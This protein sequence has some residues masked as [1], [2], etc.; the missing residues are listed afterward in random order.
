MKKKVSSFIALSMLASVM[1]T[2]CSSDKDAGKGADSSQKSP[3]VQ[4]VEFPLKEKVKYSFVQSRSDGFKPYQTLTAW[5]EQYEKKSNVQIEWQDWGT[6]DAY[7]QKSKLAFASGDL[8][9]AL[10][11]GFVI[12]GNEYTNYGSQGLLI[13]MEKMINKDIMPNLTKLIEKNPDLL[14][15]MT[16]PDGHV[17]GLPAYQEATTNTNDTILY[18]R[19]WLDK[20]GLKIPT[21]TDEFYEYLKAIKASKDLNGN[22]KDDEIP[23]TF[24]FGTNGTVDKINGI[25]SLIG[26]TGLVLPQNWVDVKD[27]KVIFVPGQPEYKEAMKYLNKLASEGLIDKEAFTMDGSAYTAKLTSKVPSV[28]VAIGWSTAQFNTP[29]GSDV[30]V[31][32][33]PLKGPDGKQRWAKRV[34]P[35]N[36]NIAFAITNKAKNP[37][38]L[39]K[40]A[41]LHYDTDASIQ[42]LNGSYDKYLKKL[43]NGVFE[44]ILKPDGKQFTGVEK[45]VDSPVNFSLY[46]ILAQ[47][48]KWSKKSA[49]TISK[50]E[51]EK[52]YGPYFQKEVYFNPFMDQKDSERYTIVGNDIGQYVTKMTAKW[53]YS[54]GVEADWNEYVNQLKKL[55]MDDFVKIDQ[56][57]YDRTK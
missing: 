48:F 8:P 16:A 15:Q 51:A 28:G 45:S 31:Y 13:P 27:G 24:R 36:F 49:A 39:L 26:F 11:G 43:D 2:G 41:D 21:T 33:P 7:K 47:D 37:E 14:K 40:W 44:E 19:L 38:I 23:F 57:A 46:A 56:K 29:I 4:S 34:T 35:A 54:G 42:N 53:I 50:E 25:S 10:Y 9:D 17:Y 30:F 32:G 18:N 12:D 5:N 3:N 55:G 1:M 6:G 52:I 22:G 20:L